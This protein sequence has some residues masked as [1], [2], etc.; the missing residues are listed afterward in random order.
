MSE[1]AQRAF[2]PGP[3]NTTFSILF[4]ERRRDPFVFFSKLARDYGD[5]C[6]L[7]LLNFRTLFINHPDDIEKMLV[8]DARKFEKG[9]VMKANMRLFGEG[10]L[11][12]EGDFWLRQRRLAQPAFHRKRV[13]AY[14]ATMVEYAER[15]MRG[16]KNGEMRDIHADM[17]KITLE[18]VGKTLFNSDLTRDARE[19]GETLEILLKLAADFGQSILIPMWVPTPRNIRGRMGIRRIEKIIYRIIAERRAEARDTGDLLSML[20]AVQ[21]EDGSR[22]TDKQL[23][24]ET[25]TLFL[26]GHETTA[27]A[28]SWTF[29]LLAK[30]PDI[31]KKFHEELAGILAGR[32]PG[33]E[34]IPKLLY[35][36]QILTESM[37]LYPPAWG[38]ARLVKEPVEVA[39][40]RLVP[41]NGVACAQWVVH[42]DPRWF[43]DP[44]KFLPERWEG[45]LAKRIPRFAY[46]PFGGGPRQCIGN[47]FALMEATL[48]LATI[49]QKFRF[50]L[51]ENHPVKPLASITLR[52]GHGIRA[53]LEAR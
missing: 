32:A 34:D 35:T 7:K 44:E 16:W 3:E 40:Y 47:S 46:F 33:V 28:I 23:R 11:T 52:P 37:R 30:N 53:T 12:S 43:D 25:I 26:A 38:M 24:D 8:D 5:V 31:E 36:S 22:M 19:V 1:A 48:I 50:R 6:G 14:G 42:R 9:R 20:L 29:W 45:D 10:L 49:A 41:G 4:G 51:D 39:G 21:D 17:M 27:N 2:P 13:N 15:A 18:V